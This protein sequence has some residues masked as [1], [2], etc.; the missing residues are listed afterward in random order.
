MLTNEGLVAFCE[1]TLKLDTLYAW[2]GMM[3]IC[4]D[5]LI[6]RLSTMYPD[7]YTQ[8]RKNR[9][10]QSAKKSYLCDCVG[11]IKAY[12]FGG[13][14]VPKYSVSKDVSTSGMFSL[15]KTK[16]K[17]N[18]LPET[19]GVILYMPGHVGVYVGNG[20]CIECT[21]GVYGDGV[22]K[23][24]IINRGWTDW[25]Y[26]P[27]IDYIVSCETDNTPENFRLN[28]SNYVVKAG[29]SFRRI[30]RCFYGTENLYWLIADANKLSV[31]TTIHP[32]QIL[33]IISKGGK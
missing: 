29:D 16:G 2:G 14:N 10:Q 33:K 12:Y 8:Q 7:K 11:L 19:K 4:T 32:G 13:I 27:F 5:N 18:T 9:L 26:C 28:Y 31:S 21:Y 23:T 6:N 20:Y 25:F 30:S 15:A 3:Q 17:I 24:S 1:N 22:V